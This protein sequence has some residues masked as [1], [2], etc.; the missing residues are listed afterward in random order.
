M[1][2]AESQP[3]DKGAKTKPIQ[4][5]VKTQEDRVKFKI[6]DFFVDDYQLY[7]DESLRF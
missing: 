7:P 6:E 2:P 5:S 1:E 3:K 4:S